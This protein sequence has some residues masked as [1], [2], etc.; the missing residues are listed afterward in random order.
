MT[1][2]LCFFIIFLSCSLV[3]LV[4]ASIRVTVSKPTGNQNSGESSSSSYSSY[5]S[6]KVVNEFNDTLFRG[7][8]LAVFMYGTWCVASSSSSS[9]SAQQQSSSSTWSTRSNNNDSTKTSKTQKTET[10]S[11]PLTIVNQETVNGT[12]SG[13][14]KYHG[15][16]IRWT[17]SPIIQSSDNRNKFNNNNDPSTDTLY[18]PISVPVVTSFL[19]LESQRAVVFDIEFPN[20]AENTSLTLL[21]NNDNDDGSTATLAT[22]PSF[23][24][25]SS[26]EEGGGER[27]EG[28]PIKSKNKKIVMETNERNKY[29]PPTFPSALSWAG[30]F[31]QS[32]R[33]LSTGSQG[34]PTVFY[35]A[36]DPFLKNVVMASQ[37]FFSKTTNNPYHSLNKIRQHRNT[38]KSNTKNHWS[39]F[40]AGNNKDWTGRNSAFSPGISGRIKSMPPGFS[41]SILLYEGSQGGITATLDEWGS[42]MQKSSISLSSRGEEEKEINKIKDVTLEKIG[43]QTDNGAMYCFCRQSNCS[44]VLLHEKEYLDSIGIPIG[45]LSFQGAGTSSGR[46]KAAP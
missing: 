32:V 39:T 27:K 6:Y 17:C 16:R 11:R 10:S 29:F 3:S 30:S 43:Y 45:Y 35:N 41:Q 21:R 26:T 33:G 5:I 7:D 28:I 4:D 40:T 38:K 9:S 44:E 37:F 19:N 14:G 13:L 31:V 34:G 24:M 12:I 20:G 2:K 22:F 15:V 36:S 18:T 1:K 46:G 42:I 25:A 23:V 8:D